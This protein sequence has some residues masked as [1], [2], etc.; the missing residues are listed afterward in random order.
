MKV[1]I[2]VPIYHGKRYIRAIIGQIEACAQNVANGVD[3]ELVLVNDAPDEHLDENILSDFIDVKVL[4]T[5]VNRG[6]HGARVRGLENSSGGYIVFLDQDDKIAPDY[7]KSQLSTIGEA[8]AVVCRVIHEKKQFYTNTNPFE[9]VLNYERMLTHGNQIVAPGH[10]LL[11]KDAISDVWIRNIMRNNG[12]DDWLLWLCMCAEGKKIVLNQEILFEHVVNGKNTSWNSDA[13][14]R[15]EDEVY[16]ILSKECMYTV[17]K[18]ALL[19]C[20]IKEK[21]LSYVHNMELFRAMFMVYDRW[22][23]LENCG[24]GLGDFL[25]KCGYRKVAIYGVGYIGKQLI[26]RLCKE[27]GLSLYAIDQNAEYITSDLPIRRLEEFEEDVDLVIVTS[28]KSAK[29]IIGN[30][31]QSEFEKIVTIEMLLD[32]WEQG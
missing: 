8:D 29:E 25:L 15:S 2:V 5:G 7:I 30:L 1:S 27:N 19:K 17:D 14:F 10:V 32:M 18:L 13:M 3:I 6:I 12:A 20:M 21:Q 11:R 23:R 28:I 24:K 22:M 4:N 26:G 16:E 31:K 9:N